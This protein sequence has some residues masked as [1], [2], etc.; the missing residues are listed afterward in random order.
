MVCYVFGN[1]SWS[2]E[3]LCVFIWNLDRQIFKI[4]F[5]AL[6]LIGMWRKSITS[7][8]NSSSTAIITST[9]SRE[10]SPRSLMKWLSRVNFSAVIWNQEILTRILSFPKLTLSKALQTLRTRASISAVSRLTVAKL[11]T[12]K[13]LQ[14]GCWDGILKTRPVSGRFN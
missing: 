2:Y 12:L 10:S 11:L 3:L 1:Q 8:P 6:V 7:N 9:W 4:W 14:A 5:L 13:S